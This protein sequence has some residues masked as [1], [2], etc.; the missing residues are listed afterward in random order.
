MRLK[1]FS[2]TACPNDEF[3][4]IRSWN[5]KMEGPIFI[6]QKTPDL[7]TEMDEFF[8]SLESFDNT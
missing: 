5:S 6:R 2:F 3:V 1:K 8:G 7:D 4:E